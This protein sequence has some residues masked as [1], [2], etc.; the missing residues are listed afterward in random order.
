MDR[1]LSNQ[2]LRPRSAHRL[3][4]LLVVCLTGCAADAPPVQLPYD[5]GG[6]DYAKPRGYL[7]QRVDGLGPLWRGPLKRNDVLDR[8]R[9]G[10]VALADGDTK[11]AQRLFADV[12][13]LLSSHGINRGKQLTYV[14]L[15]EDLRIWKGEPFEQAMAFHYT[16]LAYG[17]QGSWDNLRAAT[18]NALYHLEDY[19]LLGRA[20]DID[21]LELRAHRV[22]LGLPPLSPA[23]RGSY[24]PVQTDFALG[25]L[26]CGIAN[27]QL[28]RR[29]E[30]ADHWRA[31]VQWAPRVKSVVDRLERGDANVIIVADAGLGP[32][33]VGAGPD[34]AI[35]R[36]KPRARGSDEPLTVTLDGAQHQFPIAA[37]LNAMAENH[38]WNR[39]EALRLSKSAAGTIM[40]AG[41]AAA[42]TSDN[43]DARWAG[44]GLILAGIYAKSQAHA[45]LR[46][47]DVLPQRV[48]VAP[49]RIDAETRVKLSTGSARAQLHLSPPAGPAAQLVYVRLADPAIIDVRRSP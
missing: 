19:D 29:D 13:E 44:L 15:N 23:S 14:F 45:D 6:G 20:V 16:G 2:T 25:Y 5:V 7:Q 31:A 1:R 47:C 36:F 10:V 32:L 33:K 11:L 28:G 4:A 40:I 37:D 49:L 24:A 18:L 41:G 9:L 27:Q 46:Y 21:E 12:F 48:Y 42:A 38:K 30:A 43:R 34:G 39:Y 8:Y 26:M 35:A 17:A 3:T 22:E